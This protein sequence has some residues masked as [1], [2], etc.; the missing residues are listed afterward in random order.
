MVH[1]HEITEDRRMRYAAKPLFVITLAAGGCAPP[2]GT[3][4][5]APSGAVT[6]GVEITDPSY[7][8]SPALPTPDTAHQVSRFPRVLGWPEGKTPTAPPGFTVTRYAD[9]VV[10]P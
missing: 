1:L 3:E 7:G 2:G 6:G 4:G 5:A 8:P 9:D 10:R